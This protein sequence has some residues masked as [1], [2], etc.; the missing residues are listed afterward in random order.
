MRVRCEPVALLSSGRVMMLDIPRLTAEQADIWVNKVYKE[1]WQSIFIGQPCHVKDWQNSWRIKLSDAPRQPQDWSKLDGVKLTK[2][3]EIIRSSKAVTPG[4]LIFYHSRVRT[5]EHAYQPS[6]YK[7]AAE[8]AS[9]LDRLYVN[10]KQ[11]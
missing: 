8:V 4:F 5:L 1:S 11:S 10:S 6:Y 2:Y 3:L 7:Q 9:G